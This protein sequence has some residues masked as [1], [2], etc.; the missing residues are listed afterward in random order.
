[1]NFKVMAVDDERDVVNSLKREMKK[2]GYEFE[3]FTNPVEAIE[4][5][6]TEHF[7]LLLLDYLMSPING[8]EVVERI[9]EFNPDLYIILLTGYRDGTPSK[10]TLERLNIQVYWEKSYDY[11]QM[12][13]LVNAGIKQ[14]VLDR[15]TKKFEQGLN[16]I[17]E[18]VPKIYQLKPIGSI[19]EEI[20]LG[21]MPLVNSENAFILVDNIQDG[22]V[23]KTIFKG[24]GKYDTHEEDFI[25]LLEPTFMERLG[26]ARERKKVLK[27]KDGIVLP[28]INE[29][30]ENIG[31]IYIESRFIEDGER[32]LEIYA[33]QSSTSISNA[34]L[35]SMLNTK[36]EELK[37]TYEH[38]KTHYLDTVQALRLTVD[39]KDEYTRGHSDRVAIYAQKI[40]EA[41]KLSEK[42]LEL[43]KAGGTFH[44]I[45][46][47]GTSDDILLKPEKL[48]SYEFDIIKE[49]PI[50]GAC[51]LSAISMFNKTVPLIKYHH[52]RYDGKG[53]PEGLKGEQIPFLARILAVADAFDAMTTDRSY[54]TKMDIVKSKEQ[55]L[56]GKGTQFDPDVID[57]FMEALKDYDAWSDQLKATF[58]KTYNEDGKKISA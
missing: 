13:L 49:H 26:Y 7:D 24:I 34:M 32:L 37:R 52:E 21:I 31:I 44:D 54:R 33:K 4:R 47:I 12:H 25:N 6:K 30:N 22:E 2:C 15:K 39:A 55:L 18:A 45:G 11:S 48:N 10:D 46:K 36:K 19:L 57:K 27:T 43:L 41:F 3:G 9:R 23:G 14:V 56:M 38:L 28:L 53:Y 29:A 20:L 35:H 58:E 17:L 50:R 5:L 40:G 16:T 1:M 51:I 8:D 42:E